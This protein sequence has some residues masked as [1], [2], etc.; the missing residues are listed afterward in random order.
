MTTTKASRA[1]LWLVISLTGVFVLLHAIG[2]FAIADGEDERLMFTC[3]AALNLLTLVI[4]W[5]PLR[6]GEGWAWAASW[7]QVLVTAL[8]MPI[9][10]TGADKSLGYS[11]LGFAALLTVGLLLARPVARR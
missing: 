8:V 1:G 11:Y 6:A 9:A 4:V 10:G 3:F 5:L 7:I 2:V